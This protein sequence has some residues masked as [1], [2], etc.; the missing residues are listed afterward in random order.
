M[1][2]NSNET[3]DITWQESHPWLSQINGPEEDD[4]IGEV[5]R[6]SLDEMRF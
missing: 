2:E 6:Y 1:N 3:Q 4:S 5:V